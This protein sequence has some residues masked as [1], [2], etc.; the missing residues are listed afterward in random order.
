MKPTYFSKLPLWLSLSLTLLMVIMVRESS[1]VICQLMGIEKAA[2][3]V[4]MVAMFLMLMTWRVI[5]GLPSW[6]TTASNILLV[7]SGFAFLPVSAGAGLLLFAL[8]DELWGIVFV[9]IVS[10][11]IPL[12]GLAILS[13]R[14]LNNTADADT[15]Q[16]AQPANLRKQ[17]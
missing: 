5:K 1:V 4:G 13:H 6:L 9:M 12:W 16:K 11:L 17:S 8:G 14:W 3:V 15:E 7:D 2:N 10:T